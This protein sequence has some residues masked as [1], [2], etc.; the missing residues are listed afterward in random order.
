MK[1]TMGRIA[2]GVAVAGILGTLAVSQ[3]TVKAAS[4]TA[5]LTVQANVAAK[6]TIAA[7]NVLQFGS[8]DPVV[9]NA[10]ADLDAAT[11][12]S[13]AC[14]KGATGVWVG[15]GLGS[16]PTGS[17]RRMANGTE[18]LNYEIFSDGA[19]SSV[20]GN[21]LAS[22]VGYTPTSKAAASLNVYGRVAGG[23]DVAVG[24]Y[25]DTVVATI[26]F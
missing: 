2:A 21:A 24:N 19:R 13:V 26:N 20:W 10:T 25:S 22:G 3:A 11:T 23:Q 8:Y 9:T 12:I 17:T 1:T 4:D 6:C 15:L 7:P 5:N 18:R 14:T 16:N